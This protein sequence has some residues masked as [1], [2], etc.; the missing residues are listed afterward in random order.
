M[1]IEGSARYAYERLFIELGQNLG[2]KFYCFEDEVYEQ[3]SQISE[4]SKHVTKNHYEARIF[5]NPKYLGQNKTERNVLSLNLSAMFWK[6]WDGQSSIVQKIREDY[7]R[8]CYATHMSL[9]EIEEFLN[10][11]KPKKVYLNVIPNSTNAKREMFKR[12]KEIQSNF[13]IPSDA[14]K[15]IEDEKIKFTK[16]S[17]FKRLRSND[18]SASSSSKKFRS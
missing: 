4:I 14:E 2:Q 6:N 1:Y 11:L 17:S 5:V 8:V 16:K 18:E 15:D 7:Y 3:Y 9:E 12:L 13:M 10:Y